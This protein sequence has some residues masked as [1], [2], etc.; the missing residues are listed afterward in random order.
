MVREVGGDAAVVVFEVYPF[1]RTELSVR[2][3]GRGWVH[4]VNT[5]FSK[6]LRVDFF[7][8][9]TGWVAGAGGE[10]GAVLFTLLWVVWWFLGG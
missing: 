9:E 7:V 6:R 3:G 8:A 10:A 5:P 2:D 1:V 4:T